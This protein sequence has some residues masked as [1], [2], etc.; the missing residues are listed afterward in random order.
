MFGTIIGIAIPA[1]AVIAF[2][3]L[4]FTSY[5]K[6][7]PDQAFLISGPRKDIKVISGRAG[8]K[9]PFVDRLDKLYLGIIGVD[10]KTK[11]AVPT[12]E[13]I[14]VFVD[15]N[16]NVAVGKSDAMVR[17][18]AKNF[19]NQKADVIS[20][21]AQEV[22]EGNMREIVGQMRLTEM[23][24]DRKQ[25]A[26]KVLENAVPDMEKL[27]LEIISFNVQNFK[28]ENGVIDDLGIDN[29]E[30]IKKA[31]AI[32]KSDAK[33]DVAKVEA[34]NQRIAN[35]A[36]VEA[37]T[38]IAE[39][40]TALDIKTAELKSQSQV[41]QAAADMAYDIQKADQQKELDVAQTNAKIA[42]AERETALKAQQIELKEKELDAIVRKKADADLYATQKAAEADL[43][44]RQ[45]EAEAKAYEQVK[46]SEAAKQAALLEAEARK[47]M[48]DAEKYAAEAEAAGIAAKY[49]AEAE[50]IRAKGLAEAEGI[51][52][53]AEA[54]KKMGEASVLEMYFDMLPSAIRAAAEP[55][56]NVDKVVLYG[57]G[58]QTKLIQ[59][60]MNTTTQVIDA[61]K[62]STGI[63]LAQ[64]IGSYIGA[65]AADK[66]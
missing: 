65:K 56:L 42:Q 32:A 52:K 40:N 28:D 13:Y 60:T 12:A 10:V 62:E 66:E 53:K 48:A 46:K 9:V 11:S 21:K 45:R 50:G 20:K 35:E 25:F 14:N 38:K 51:D 3:V 6:A 63:D 39:Q 41:K 24:S 23:V 8:F 27:G 17:I 44:K 15:A 1:V 47:A 49:A 61:I 33:R 59:D 43:A 34:E 31:A 58:A 30:Q 36:Q 54:Q 4:A 16:V 22:L 18:A 5:V 29:V 55:M 37:A 2:L 57:D 26:E 64:V 7:P 19:L